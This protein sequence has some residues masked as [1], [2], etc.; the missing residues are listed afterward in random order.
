MMNATRILPFAFNI[1]HSMGT[2]PSELAPFAQRLVP[3][4]RI[5]ADA[6]VPAGLVAHMRVRLH[7]D[8]LFV[9]EDAALRRAPDVKHYHLAEQLRRTLVTLDRDYLDDRRFPPAQGAGVL[10]ISAPDERELSTLLD[11]LD[12]TLFRRDD[13]RRPG[14]PAA[15]RPQTAR[16]HR[17]GPRRVKH[18]LGLELLDNRAL[19]VAIDETG[20]VLGRASVASADLGAAALATLDGAAAGSAGSIG[21]LGVA[22]MTPESPECTA[23]LTAIG[24]RY[25]GSFLKDGAFASGTAAVVAETW[26]GAARDA[27]DVVYF[28]VGDHTSAGIVRD[29]APLNG[30]HRRA[31][32]VA[33]LALNPVEREDYR[34]TG[35]LEA[36]VAAAGIMRRL[37]WRI[38]AGDRSRVQ[39]VVNGD[40]AA[41]TTAHILD[42]AR[43]RRRRLHLGRPRHRQIS[44]H[45]RGQSRRH[46]GS[47]GA[48][49]R[50]DHGVRRGPPARS[51]PGRDRAS[52]A[53]G[54]DGH[55]DDCAR[56]ARRR[57]RGARRG[58]AGGGRRRMIVLSGAELV[59]PDRILTPGTLA[60]DDGRI[61]DIRPGGAQG[62]LPG[63][64]SPSHFA[65]H[66]HYIVPG[67]IDVHVHGVDGF[68]S[69]DGDAAVRAIAA[70]LPRY[71]VTAFC[72]TTVACSPEALR[73][74]LEQVRSARETPDARSARVL[75]AHLESNFI[76]P[77]YRGAQPLGCL[78][79]PQ[80]GARRGREDA[81]G[82]AGRAGRPGADDFAASDILRE[83]ERA[84]PD[85]GIVTI[86]PE[87][88]G[89]L[90]LVRW[91]LARGPRVSLGHSQR[92][93]RRGTRR[94]RRGRA[95]RDASLQPDA[96]AG[97]SRAWA[98]RR[99]PPDR[100]SRRGADLRRLPRAPRDHAHGDCGEAAVAR[101]G[102]H[103]RHRRVRPRRWAGAR[104]S[105][106][107][108][109]PRAN[110]PPFSTTAR[111]PAAC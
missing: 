21:G 62:R 109:S 29:G 64:H 19:A 5:Y 49:A 90:D 16:A 76:N 111:W 108:R 45:G 34:K 40:F 106:D 91:I 97:P 60:I 18:I 87:L 13:D 51:R 84:A 67:F 101:H 12:S 73:V 85:V 42:A 52:R 7:W 6:N 11:R 69:L 72:P 78:R 59:L 23:A 39:D 79:S 66:G 26:I 36:E 57:R 89:G 80:H 15:R 27:R 48:G 93:V 35:C 8:V 68:D 88:D 83:I 33:W 95:P 96:A 25:P 86:A 32:A 56:G 61:V 70:R 46:R 55:A 2:L 54:D 4:P 110:R 81:A 31:P 38:K 98:C 47:G 94:D 37:V 43:G 30:A 3:R 107:N 14:D 41:I 103:G 104:A 71:G 82:G 105:A 9:L 17:L 74:V 58:A 75:P 10:V 92:D 102:H 50:G 1:H 44:R 24:T 65:F 22:S 28:A 53:A 100:R 20:R 63:G 77:E 99:H